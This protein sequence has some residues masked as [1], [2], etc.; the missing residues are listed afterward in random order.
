MNSWHQIL[1]N[2]TENKIDLSG[3]YLS[4]NEDNPRKWQFPNGSS[5]NPGAYLVIWAD[6]DEEDS[7]LGELH[8]NFKLSSDGEPLS[9]ISSDEEGNLIMEMITL[10]L[11]SNILIMTVI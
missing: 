3:W 2:R 5:I 10:E 11:F 9:L 7:S 1:H 6:E 4:D 8:T